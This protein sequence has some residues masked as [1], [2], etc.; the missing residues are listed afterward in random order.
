MKKG[1]SIAEALH[2][3]F[4]YKETIVNSRPL[5]AVSD[6]AN[7]FESLTPNPFLIGRQSPYMQPTWPI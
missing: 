3:V 2:I 5:T 6:D 1:P 4:I 7:N